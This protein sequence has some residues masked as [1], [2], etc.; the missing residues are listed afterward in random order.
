M[1][2]N[3]LNRKVEEISVSVITC[4]VLGQVRRQQPQPLHIRRDFWV[5][6]LFDLFLEIVIRSGAWWS[7]LSTSVRLIIRYAQK[8]CEPPLCRATRPS[9][10]FRGVARSTKYLIGSICY[11]VFCYTTVYVYNSCNCT[12]GQ[13][14]HRHTP[15]MRRRRHSSSSHNRHLYYTAIHNA[16]RGTF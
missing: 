5:L 9:G 6:L 10:V 16:T 2:I 3:H 1:C 7:T 14:H 15:S 13:Q 12:L 11:F 8:V 4:C